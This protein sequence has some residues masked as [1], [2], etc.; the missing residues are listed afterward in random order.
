ME[1]A[2]A[3][4]IVSILVAALFVYD[5]PFFSAAGPTPQVLIPAGQAWPPTEGGG[6]GGAAGAGFTAN[7]AGTLTGGFRVSVGTVE[8]C[9]ATFFTGERWSADDPQPEQC[10]SNVTYSSGFVASAEISVP[11][12]AGPLWL[13]CFPGLNSTEYS[14][15]WNVT[16]SPAL[17][18]VPS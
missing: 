8:V 12:S 16:W 18:I 13:T 14:P 15:P 1:T 17:E 6:H 2:I 3:L 5:A 7:Q 10:P 4:L 9:E 11:V